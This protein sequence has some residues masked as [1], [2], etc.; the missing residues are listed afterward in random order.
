[1]SVSPIRLSIIIGSVREGRF[2]PVVAEW[3]SGRAEQRDELTV[4]VVDLLE[5]GVPGPGLARSVG[6]AD[7]VVVVTPEYNHSFPGP[8]KTAVDSLRAEWRAKPVGLVCY[9]GI[10]GGLRAA[11]ALR[12]VFA[13]LHAMTVRE[14]V[15]FHL[16]PTRFDEHGDPRDPAAVN[17]AADALIDQLL[18]W[19]TALR[20]ARAARPYPG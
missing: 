9:G 10:S 18:W 17:A 7:A 1:M 20:A 5:D 2:G 3:F 12:L 11:E 16:A 13:E 19:A 15:S 14:T 4:E 6:A 8:L